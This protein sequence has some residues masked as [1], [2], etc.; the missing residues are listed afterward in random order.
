MDKWLIELKKQDDEQFK[1]IE[2]LEKEMDRKAEERIDKILSIFRPHTV[3]RKYLA[4]LCMEVRLQLF[5]IRQHNT[6]APVPTALLRAR[7]S[8]DKKYLFTT[9]QRHQNDCI[10]NVCPSKNEE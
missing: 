3:S 2:E 6:Q 7:S 1:K 10:H 4:I 9:H 8:I 5:Y